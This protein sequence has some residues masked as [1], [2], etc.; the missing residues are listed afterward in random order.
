MKH[1]KAIVGVSA[2]LFLTSFHSA[3]AEELLESASTIM[4]VQEGLSM[5]GYPVL[6]SGEL[7]PATREALR[8][9]QVN[10]GIRPPS[11]LIDEETLRELRIDRPLAQ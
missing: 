3:A 8:Q 10:N 7:D 4:E 2:L 1:T 9:F 6:L 11:G 5:R